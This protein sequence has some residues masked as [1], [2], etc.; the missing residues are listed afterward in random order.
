M[1]WYCKDEKHLRSKVYWY[2]MDKD[3]E[4]LVNNCLSCQKLSNTRQT[5]PVHMTVLHPGNT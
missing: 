1:S 2:K 4:D 3:I 5:P